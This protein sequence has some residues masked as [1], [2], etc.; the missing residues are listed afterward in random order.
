MGIV[1][2][3]SCRRQGILGRLFQEWLGRLVHECALAARVLPQAQAGIFR[4]F[5]VVATAD[6]LGGL[7]WVSARVTGFCSIL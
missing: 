7:H 1:S 3:P 5:C 4:S 6:I 2:L